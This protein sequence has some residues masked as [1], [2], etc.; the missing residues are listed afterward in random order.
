M[1]LRAYSVYDAKSLAY[2][3]PF[4]APTDGSAIR[5]FQGLANDLSTTVGQF[6]TDFS[7]WT[8]GHYDD[9]TGGLTPISPLAHVI[10][11][12][13]LVIVQPKLPLQSFAETA[14]ELQRSGELRRTNGAA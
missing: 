9:Q 13:A 7:L 2:G 4:F 5:S 14:D 8:V 6:P 11:A 1:Q 3:V 10:D 12:N